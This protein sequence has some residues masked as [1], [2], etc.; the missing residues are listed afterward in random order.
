MALLINGHACIVLRR[1]ARNTL[2]SPPLRV[3]QVGGAAEL[4]FGDFVS[5]TLASF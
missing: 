3:Q 1:K 2:V 5:V 4:H